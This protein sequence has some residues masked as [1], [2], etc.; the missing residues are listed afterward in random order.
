[1]GDVKALRSLGNESYRLESAFAVTASDPVVKVDYA[2]FRD[3]WY[4][5]LTMAWKDVA[6]GAAIDR[7]PVSANEQ[8]APGATLFVPFKLSPGEDRTSALGI[9]W[10]AQHSPNDLS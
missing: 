8:P 3:S 4:D 2:W 1:L 6:S 5:A 10:Y 9:T 7:P